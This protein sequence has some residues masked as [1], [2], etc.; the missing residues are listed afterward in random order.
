M[1]VV[2]LTPPPVGDLW[3]QKCIVS[4]RAMI[5][6]DGGDAQLRGLVALSDGV[7]LSFVQFALD[8]LPKFY[9][10]LFRINAN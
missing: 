7:A 10:D 2:Q 3:V 9:S 6:D 4:P 5:T 8:N 1:G